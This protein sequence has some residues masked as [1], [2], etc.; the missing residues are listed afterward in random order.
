MVS[1]N[2]RGDLP[3][4]HTRLGSNTSS[5]VQPM[6]LIGTVGPAPHKNSCY[7]AAKFGCGG[8]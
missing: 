2:R 3:G 7:T 6:K 8:A 5:Q 1:S 4:N